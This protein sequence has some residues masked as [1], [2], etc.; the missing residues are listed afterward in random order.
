[1][2]GNLS[3]SLVLLLLALSYIRAADLYDR[4]YTIQMGID[5]D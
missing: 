5:K 4:S 2:D 3:I 1:M